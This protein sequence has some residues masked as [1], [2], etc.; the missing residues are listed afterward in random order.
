MK[1]LCLQTCQVRLSDKI[2][3]VKQGE[4]VRS[5]ED[6]GPRFKN[7][8]APDNA[9]YEVDFL[10]AKEEE[11]TNT[12][13]KFEEARLAIY[14]KYGVELKREE[15]TKKSEIIAQILDARFRSIGA[16]MF[17]PVKQD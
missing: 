14:G 16:G 15:G 3:L 9:S 13:W 17:D 10:T 2:T 6:L 7:L 12:K 1:H 8:E 5:S 4:V 11:L